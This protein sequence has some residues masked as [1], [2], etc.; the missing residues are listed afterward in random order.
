VIADKFYD[1]L[2]SK[3]PDSKTPHRFC[4]EAQNY[5]LMPKRDLYRET[6]R[7]H[8]N[9]NSAE[10]Q[11]ADRATRCRDPITEVICKGKRVACEKRDERCGLAFVP[12]YSKGEYGHLKSTLRILA[13]KATRNVVLNIRNVSA[14]SAQRLTNSSRAD[15]EIVIKLQGL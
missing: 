11:T 7:T 4:D 2:H 9:A 14:N 13:V 8:H 10:Y 5:V 3:D 6:Y 15:C 12:L 1:T